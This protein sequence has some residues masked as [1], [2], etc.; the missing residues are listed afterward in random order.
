MNISKLF[1]L[2]RQ[3]DEHIVREHPPKEGEDRL[4]KK[5]LA[6][7]VELGELANE[8][9]GFKFW[10][11]DQEPRIEKRTYKTCP[12]CNGE[13]D[14]DSCWMC[15]N[16]GQVAVKIINPLLEEYLDCLRFILSI[17][18]ELNFTDIDVWK[19]KEIN[20][21]NQFIECLGAVYSLH[22][23][24]KV[25][26]EVPRIMYEHLLAYL[27]GLGKMLGFTWEQIEEAYFDKVNNWGTKN[28]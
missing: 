26:G 16:R 6:L 4:A 8:W 28:E 25:S 14:V 9:R 17:G 24:K 27:I 2:Q 1:E 22:V 18:L 19:F 20:I 11:Y 12:S 7:Q 10:S 5:I 13:Y 15:G 23:Q 21:T 3:L